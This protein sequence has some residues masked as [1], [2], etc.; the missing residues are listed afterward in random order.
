MTRRGWATVIVGAWAVSLGWL[1]KRTYFRST[2]A[3]LAEAALAV[4]PGAMFYRLAV[5]AQ[6]L[7]YASTTI[8]TLR[9]S[10]RVED[11]L[12]IDVP[13][14]GKLHRSS[15]RSEAILD[16]ALRLRRVTA[17]YDGEGGRVDAHAAISDDSVLHVTIITGDDSQATT[18]K[19][20]RPIILP[21]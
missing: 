6:Q 11:V 4:P 12:V 21:S 5:G 3:K 9:D 19:L 16:R 20:T 15:G 7:G 13:A 1:V 8:D 2:G 10:I 17:S 18:V 14:L